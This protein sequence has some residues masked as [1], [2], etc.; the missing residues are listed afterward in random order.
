[1][2]IIIVGTRGRTVHDSSGQATT[3]ICRHCS[4]LVS[5]A[6]V[7]RK[8]YFTIFFIPLFPLEKGQA[9]I[10]CPNCKTM[11]QRKEP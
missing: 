6:P 9:A 5:F 3:S 2:P 7:R 4:E 1:M 11:Y 8:R 10:Q